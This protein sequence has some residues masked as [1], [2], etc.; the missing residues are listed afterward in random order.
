MSNEQMEQA[1][2]AEEQQHAWEVKNRAWALKVAADFEAH[3]LLEAE[4]KANPPAVV[5][6][7][8]PPSYTCQHLAANLKDP[9]RRGNEIISGSSKYT[10]I[11]DELFA[12]SIAVGKLPSFERRAGSTLLCTACSDAYDMAIVSRAKA[13]YDK[14]HTPQPVLE[15]I[16]A[17]ANS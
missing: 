4:I 11:N 7:M 16:V 14:L 5:E 9:F 1:V 17:T 13:E 2:T 15:E 10:V 12:A 6:Y 8:P 3:K